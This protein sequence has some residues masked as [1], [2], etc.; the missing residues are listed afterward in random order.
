MLEFLF[1]YTFTELKASYEKACALSDENAKEV[2]DLIDQLADREKE[3]DKH[4]H[5]I[6]LQDNEIKENR[7][8]IKYV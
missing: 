2:R 6:Q 7:D 4:R 5:Q 1:Y 8:K 3:V